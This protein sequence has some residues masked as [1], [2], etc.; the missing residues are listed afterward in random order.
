MNIFLVSFGLVDIFGFILVI[1]GYCVFCINCFRNF[2]LK[3]IVDEEI[4]RFFDVVKDF[5]WLMFVFSFF[6]II[7]DRYL[8]VI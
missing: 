2:S 3:Q 7:Y 6:G 8:V 1:L 4:C 5:V